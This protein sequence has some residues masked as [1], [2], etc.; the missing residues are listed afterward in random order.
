M[1]LN[2]ASSAQTKENF[3]FGAG[4]YVATPIGNFW[5]KEY[6]IGIGFVG[7]AR[8]KISTNFE[9]YS[10]L[11]VTQFKGKT[12]NDGYYTDTNDN[13]T[14]GSLTFGGRYV[15]NSKLLI[16]P[17]SSPLYAIESFVTSCIKN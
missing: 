2:L 17:I 4:A 7:T 1:F 11:G 5:V 10:N 8:Y 13:L 14:T 3:S 6:G 16:L 9:I 15:S 12:I